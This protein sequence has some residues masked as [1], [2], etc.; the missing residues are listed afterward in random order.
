VKRALLVALALSSLLVLTA[1]SK[2]SAT[3]TSTTTPRP[4]VALPAVSGPV[5]GGKGSPTL[6]TAA[7]D[8]PT[9]GYTVEEY[10]LDGTATA[11]TSDVAL[12]GDGA[13]SVAPQGTAPYTTRIVVYR[14]AKPKDFD[15]TVYVEWNNVSAGF[16][17]AP[18]WGSGHTAV[19][20]EGAAWIAVSAQ[21]VGVQGG[22]TIIGQTAPGGLRASDPDRYVSLSHPGDSYSYDIYSQ[23][24]AV[25]RNTT[26]PRVL[27]K[28][29]VKH[30][31]S[32]GE[33]QSA[34]RLVTY[35]NALQPRDHVY[36]GF[37]VHSNVSRAASLS[38]APLASVP[39]PTPTPIR[40]DLDVPVFLLETETDVLRGAYEMRR[41]D[42]N[43]FRIW[44]IAGASHADFYQ[45]GGFGDIGDGKTERT[46]LDVASAA[47][48]PLGCAEPINYGPQYLVLGA[49]LHHVDRWVAEGVAPPKA[50]PLAVAPGPPPVVDRDEHGNALGG[51]RTPL[52]DVPTARL[53]GETN[54]GGTFCFLYGHTVP[55]DAATLAAL[56]PHH[57]DYVMKFN[58]A[59]DAAVKA[60][61]LLAAD[62]KNLKAA[63]AASSV[64]AP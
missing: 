34:G 59:T 57:R 38:S 5:T 22:Q 52:V 6:I 29:K 40:S 46:L 21:A 1:A 42:T 55:F 51:V 35:A 30:V 20:R 58:R 11:Y 17:T 45:G 62:A 48:G 24:G 8:W 60:G 28:L 56:Y 16:D 4:T 7:V 2:P 26:R 47:G 43:R 36:D 25:A 32:V 19:L 9:E 44:E 10:F 15:G 13:W 23:A 14:P 49:A 31:I 18:D 39:A 27:G 41:P 50:Q 3:T 61:F 53:D 37:L 54:A 64:G 33:S 63:A 12:T